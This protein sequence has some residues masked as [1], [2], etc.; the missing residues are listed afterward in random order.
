MPLS[1]GT[2]PKYPG[3]FQATA[4]NP[5]LEITNTITKVSGL[6]NK[7]HSSPYHEQNKANILLDCFPVYYEIVSQFNSVSGLLFSPALKIKLAQL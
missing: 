1:I 6:Y 5:I 3:I 4:G 2:T 7:A